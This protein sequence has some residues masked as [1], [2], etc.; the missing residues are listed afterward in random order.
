MQA[1]L[2]PTYRAARATAAQSWLSAPDL[3]PPG[4]M[5]YEVFTATAGI[6]FQRED[7]S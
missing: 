4:A 6:R 1:I 7:A 2:N 5:L 3:A